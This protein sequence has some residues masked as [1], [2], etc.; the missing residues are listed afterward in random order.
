MGGDREG[1]VV[2]RLQAA[3]PE[4]EPTEWTQRE[5]RPWPQPE[6]TEWTQREVRPWPQPGAGSPEI[7][8]HSEY[9][10]AGHP[11]VAGDPV[12]FDS[13][14]YIRGKQRSSR[15]SNFA[16]PDYRYHGPLI[17]AH[18]VRAENGEHLL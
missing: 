2:W 10:A 3:A 9:S 13:A 7:P 16:I 6:P 8:L 4:S 15:L 11:R 17:D 14:H 12:R 18:Y 1:P 5:V